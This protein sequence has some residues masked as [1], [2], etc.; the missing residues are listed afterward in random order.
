[1]EFQNYDTVSPPVRE[2]IER[3]CGIWKS[4]LGEDLLGIY[5]HGSMALGRFRENVSDIDLLILTKKR[6][7]RQ[8]RLNLAK[9]ILM[10]D[11]APRPLEMSA[12][13]YRDL[14]PWQHPAPCQFHYSEYHRKRYQNLLNGTLSGSFLLDTDFKDPDI[15][16]HVRLTRQCG[17]CLC[18]IPV[19]EAFP[20]VPEED[21]WQSLCQD[22]EEYDF[23]AYSPR[24]FA[25]NLLTL[26]RILSYKQE[27]RILSKYDAGLW[28]LD[29]LPSSFHGLVR[30][31]IREW[32]GG[33]PSGSHSPAAL[34]AL[35]D[36]LVQQIKT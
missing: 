27:H 34:Q 13:F 33:E 11:Q 10:V 32:Y 29:V 15:A 31:A 21:F 24:Y 2:Q 18:G 6:L 35:R 1:M 5:L 20:I 16:C 36:Y 17:I 25:S 12:L 4:R 28:A 8:T 23:Y 22:I 14:H 26:V 7:P 9:E 3:V 19:K 30:Q